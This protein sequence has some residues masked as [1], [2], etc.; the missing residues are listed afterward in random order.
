MAML[1]DSLITGDLRVTGTIYGIGTNLTNIDAS[2]ITSG[3]LPVARG[4]TGQTTAAG[5]FNVVRDNGGNST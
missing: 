1:K 3:T 4:G 5:I 2:Q